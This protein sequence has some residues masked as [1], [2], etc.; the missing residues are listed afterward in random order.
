MVRRL[1]G[2]V[3]AVAVGVAVLSSPVRASPLHTDGRF[4]RDAQGGAVVLRGVNTAGNAKLPPFRP[5]TP[6]AFDPLAAWGMNV[7]RLLF[8][9]E[10]YEPSAGVYDESYLDYYAGLVDAA[11]A[12]G[13]R[14]IVDFHQDAY[15]RF[16]VN[17]CG[18]GFPAWT[19]PWW[20][21][22]ATPDNTAR[23]SGWGAAMITDIAMHLAWNAFH[24]DAIG[25]RTRYLAM[26]G[27]VAARLASHDAVVGYDM[28]NEPWGDEA[29]EIHRLHEDAA[30]AIRHWHPGAVLFVSP[31]ALISSGGK[32]ALPRPSF[33]N[34]VYAPHFYD[35]SVVV[36]KN[37]LGGKPDGAF[38]NMRSLAE[39]WNVPLLVGEYGADA[40]TVN[41]TGYMAAIYD[42]LDAALASG[43]QWSYTPGWTSTAGDGWNDENMSIVD[44]TGAARA[45]FTP[46]PYPRRTSGTPTYFFVDTAAHTVELAWEHVAATGATEL[47]VPSTVLAVEATA[48]DALTCT[49]SSASHL[50]TCSSPTNGTKVIRVR[51]AP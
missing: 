27:R 3:V 32:S 4:L 37:W 50:V 5:L 43:T 41:V 7:V 26:V 8:T 46:R 12:R 25:T 47:F 6:A 30:V 22:R 51:V 16:S 11:G 36:F 39:A 31:H 2:L 15:S 24:T 45:N 18:E 20:I 29:T 19:I 42:G 44:S 48:G 10:A 40:A 33:A 49:S 34:F 13:L 28:M 38:A 9:W 21:I 14:V 17:G 23:C 1:A 35:A